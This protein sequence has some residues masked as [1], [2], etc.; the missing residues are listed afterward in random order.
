MTIKVCKC[1]FLGPYQKLIGV[2]ICNELNTPEE[3]KQT[4]FHSLEPPITFSDLCRLVRMFRLYALWIPFSGSG[5]YL[6]R[7]SSNRGARKAQGRQS[8]PRSS[9]DCGIMGTAHSWTILKRR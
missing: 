1:M 4:A 6:G 7:G 5:C 9:V 8:K 3:S 2:N